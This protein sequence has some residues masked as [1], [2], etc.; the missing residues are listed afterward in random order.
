MV[1]ARKQAHLE[2]LLSRFPELLEGCEIIK[3]SNR[4]YPVRIIVD[5][6][7]WGHVLLE[8]NEEQTWT[9]FKN[10]VYSRQGASAYEQILHRVWELMFQFGKGK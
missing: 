5:R 6:A 9:N 8:M 1:R 3:W 7:S 4:D 2:N 10:E